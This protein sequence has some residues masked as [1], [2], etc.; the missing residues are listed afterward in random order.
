MIYQTFNILS[1]LNLK[2]T[3]YYNPVMK[4][5]ILALIFS[6]IIH[7]LFLFNYEIEKKPENFHDKK[8]ENKKKKSS[9]TYVQL[10][11]P[12]PIKKSKPKI[13]K[14]KPTLKKSK[15]RDFKE[16]KKEIKPQK[17]R[18]N[19]VKTKKKV[20][21][22]PKKILK[23][24]KDFKKV[25]KEIKPQERRKTV[26]K[27]SLENFLLENPVLD[28]ELLD[29]VTKS[30]IKLY[31]DEYEKFTK[32]Q[33]AFLQNNLKDIGRITQKYLSSKGYP[34]IAIRTKQQGVN[35]VEF[36]LYPNGDIKGLK[37]INSS[38]YRVLDENSIDTIKIA[39]KD[40]PRPKEVTKIRIYVHYRLY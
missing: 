24:Q 9:I 25:K 8:I 34:R 37:V 17:R 29:D 40:Y 18:E 6:I 39:Y 32:V 10:K 26:D 5:F 15:K 21:K 2:A 22:K 23:K 36:F 35:V 38:S 1:L 7:I 3:L 4:T 13:I 14:E 16:V 31:G 30:Y 11:K 19:I 33:K 28:K 12:K 27:S 20:I